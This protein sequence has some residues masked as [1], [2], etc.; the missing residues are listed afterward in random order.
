MKNPK[1][2]KKTKR[3]T[4]VPPY[5][6]GGPRPPFPPG[7]KLDGDLILKPETWKKIREISENP[8][9]YMHDPNEDCGDAGTLYIDG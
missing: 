1:T 4:C 2:P 9:K 5:P 7:T 3:L 6:G 8:E